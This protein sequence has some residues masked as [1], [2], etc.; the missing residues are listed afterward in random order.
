MKKLN[1]NSISPMVSRGDF[2]RGLPFYG[3]KGDFNFTVSRS[4]FTPGISVSQAPLTDMSVKGDPGF[5]EFDMSVAK[6]KMYFKPGDR[7]RGIAV[8]SMLDHENGKVVVG[9][10]QKIVPDYSNNTIKVW[11]KNPKTLEI[12]EVYP[13]SIERIYESH[14]AMS[15]TQF[16][17]S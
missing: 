9:K 7:I 16:I 13:E 17:N 12:Q 6:L 4:R 11:V 10:L 14:R 1:E 15:F 5:S 3:S 2:T 8:N